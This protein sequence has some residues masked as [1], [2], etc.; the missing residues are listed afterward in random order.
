[1]DQTKWLV[2]RIRPQ[3]ERIVC[4]QLKDWYNITHWCPFQTVKRRYTDRIKEVKVPVFKGYVFVQVRDYPQ[5]IQVLRTDGVTD[6]VRFEAVPATI[7][8]QEITL[9]REFL[10]Q[11]EQ[12][13]VT[14]LMKGTT[15]VVQSGILEG[16]SGMIKDVS[17]NKVILELP[18]LGFLL[19]VPPNICETR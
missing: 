3:W 18:R 10:E 19:E 12:V 4:R 7:S 6:Y 15:V 5:Q 13:T 1:M 17:K 2:A 8:D 9:L 16:Q 14:P 11:H